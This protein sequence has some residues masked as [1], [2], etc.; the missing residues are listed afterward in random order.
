MTTLKSIE[1]NILLAHKSLKATSTGVG[2]GVFATM[3]LS[4]ATLTGDK[5]NAL[6]A[7][8][9]LVGFAA[10]ATSYV[11]SV[12]FERKLVSGQMSIIRAY[13]N[14]SQVERAHNATHKTNK[15]DNAVQAIKLGAGLAAT[16]LSSLCVA[17]GHLGLAFLATGATISLA[18]GALSL[19]DTDQARK[20]RSNAQAVR[21]SLITNIIS[22]RKLPIDVKI[23]NMK[24]KKTL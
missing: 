3:Y 1:N 4:H 9:C 24:A 12:Y 6:G 13:G 14:A 21:K 16:T 5:L 19:V 2:I 15:L 23:P 8:V 7:G 22:R 20:D 17:K 10:L 18:C 11:A